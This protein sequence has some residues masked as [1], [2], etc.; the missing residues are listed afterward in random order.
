MC[1]TSFRHP[2][3][4]TFGGK[5]SVV[6]L[7]KTLQMRKTQLAP[8]DSDT[9]RSIDLSEDSKKSKTLASNFSPGK[10]DVIC[11]RGAFAFVGNRWF[12]IVVNHYAQEL[13]LRRCGRQEKSAVVT[14]IVEAVH[15]AGG[16]FVRQNK[17]TEA[18][19]EV[20]NRVA[21][22]KVGHALREAHKD[23]RSEKA[24]KQEEGADRTIV[25][26]F[27]QQPNPTSALLAHAQEQQQQRT[28]AGGT[29]SDPLASIFA[30]LK[31]GDPIDHTIATQ[32]IQQPNPS[33]AHELQQKQRTMADETPLSHSLASIVAP[34]KHGERAERTPATQFKQLPSPFSASPAHAQEQ[35][36]RTI[37]AEATLADPLASSFEPST[38]QN[39]ESSFSFSKSES[40]N[41]TDWMPL[42]LAD[43]DKPA[44]ATIDWRSLL[45]S[46]EKITDDNKDVGG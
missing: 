45:Q 37:T 8:G 12:R 43:A 39:Q 33:N 34:W 2:T 1:Q 41:E 4:T 10:Y 9:F 16:R 11:Q 44:P 20:T 30:P 28:I 17:E 46:F 25:A 15:T 24:R 22:E 14:K 23:L 21:R 26:Q 19:C 27:K 42:P 31:Q 5:L 36:Q 35:Q 29:L 38:L 3:E 6:V 13:P 18:W 7:T 32:F 40:E